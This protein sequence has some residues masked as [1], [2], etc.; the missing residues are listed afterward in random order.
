ME[1]TLKGSSFRIIKDNLYNIE[2][3]IDGIYSKDDIKAS[4]FLE[5]RWID[6]WVGRVPIQFLE[7]RISEAKR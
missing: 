3:E 6:I 2:I 7:G 1:L 4:P 5:F